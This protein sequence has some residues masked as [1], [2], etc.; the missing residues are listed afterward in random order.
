MAERYPG[1][2]RGA[3][4]IEDFSPHLPVVGIKIPAARANN[5]IDRNPRQRTQ[6]G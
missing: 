2:K 3:A 5:W 6:P 4:Y 1:K